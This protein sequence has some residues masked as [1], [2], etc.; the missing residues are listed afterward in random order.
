[1]RRLDLLRP[2]RRLLTLLV[3]LATL[4][5]AAADAQRKND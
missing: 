3:A 2:T 4:A 1:M 5:T